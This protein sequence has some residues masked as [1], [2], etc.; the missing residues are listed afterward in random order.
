MDAQKLTQSSLQALQSA[1]STA[2][3]YGNAELTPVHLCLALLNRDGLIYQ[4][5]KK[6]G[7]DTDG[8]TQAVKE[9]VERRAPRAQAQAMSICP[10]RSTAF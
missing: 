6:T 1:Q 9:E 5:L 8:F 2:V 3:E 10:R 4:I 7:T